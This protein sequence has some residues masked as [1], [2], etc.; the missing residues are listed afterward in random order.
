M[1]KSKKHLPTYNDGVVSI[2]REKD[3]QTSFGAKRNVEKIEDID[4]VVSLAFYE[5]SKREEDFETAERAGFS[6][7]VKLRTHNIEE[8]GG[9]AVNSECKAVIGDKLYDIGSID[10]A[11]REM[12]LYLGGGRDI[13]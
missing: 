6:L 1:L 10:R 2:Y 5:C 9:V 7:D 4:L 12:F 11:K 3:R 8:L 13:E